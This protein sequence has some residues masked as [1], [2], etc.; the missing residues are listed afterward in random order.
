[1]K[2]I[3]AVFL[4]LVSTP[5]LAANRDCNPSDNCIEVGKKPLITV[6]QN[7]RGIQAS[8][9]DAQVPEPPIFALIGVGMA[10]LLLMRKRKIKTS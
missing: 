8:L 6:G 7:N 9:A 5:L 4:L 1:M 3:M 10:G 2:T